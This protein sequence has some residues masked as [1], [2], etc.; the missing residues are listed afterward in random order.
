MK[1]II[2]IVVV[3]ALLY[4]LMKKMTMMVHVSM[5]GWEL[6]LFTIVLTGIGVFIVDKL[7]S[8]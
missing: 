1:G 3:F 5:A 8:S 7:K 4:M 6:I 2:L